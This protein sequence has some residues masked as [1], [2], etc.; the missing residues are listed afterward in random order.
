MKIKNHQ[1]GKK[2]IYKISCE[3]YFNLFVQ[4]SSKLS[5]FFLNDELTEQTSAGHKHSDY[6]N[7]IERGLKKYDIANEGHNYANITEGH[8]IGCFL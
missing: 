5:P 6:G 2:Y 3:L 7:P 1:S 8:N 4:F